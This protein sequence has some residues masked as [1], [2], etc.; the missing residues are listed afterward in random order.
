M[1]N[2][3][4]IG[5][6]AV[7]K[8]LKVQILSYIACKAWALIEPASIGPELLDRVTQTA[9]CPPNVGQ[10]ETVNSGLVEDKHKFLI[11]IFHPDADKCFRQRTITKYN[12][13]K[14]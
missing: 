10:A 13:V 9:P 12:Y 14:I 1:K 3:G 2:I 8:Y 11:S 5:L 4:K 7:S 6:W